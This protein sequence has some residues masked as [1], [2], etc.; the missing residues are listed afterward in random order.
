M[1]KVNILGIDRAEDVTWQVPVLMYLSSLFFFSLLAFWLYRVT[2]KDFAQLNLEKTTIESELAGLRIKT[3]E[4]RDLEDK[5]KELD[6]KLSVIAVLKKNKIGPVRVM[7]DINNALPER[8]WITD[9]SEKDG[10][11]TLN[12]LALDPTTVSTFAKAL[13]QSTF[14]RDVEITEVN[15]STYETV[16]IQKFNVRMNVSYSG[17]LEDIS[18]DLLAESAIKPV[19]PAA[20]VAKKEE[21]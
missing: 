21:E 3:K 4:V 15:Q 20:P 2:A 13:S 17:F 12:G 1:I 9:L 10:V 6:S 5:R 16:P 14:N 7:D 18:E 11:M 19:D 8:A